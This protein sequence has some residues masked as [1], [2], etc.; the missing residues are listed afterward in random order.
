MGPEAG[1]HF[2]R[3]CSRTRKTPE[4]PDEGRLCGITRARGEGLEPSIT[5]PEPAVLPITPPPTEVRSG[6]L[7]PERLS[8]TCHVAVDPHETPE[9]DHPAH[10]HRDR[11]AGHLLELAGAADRTGA[12][13]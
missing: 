11:L 9:P 2:T 5:G 7:L 12:G 1:C 10:P 8:Y 6:Y 3:R 13:R 4:A